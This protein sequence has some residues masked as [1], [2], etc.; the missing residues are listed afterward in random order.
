MIIINGKQVTAIHAGGKAVQMVYKG[1]RLVWQAVTSCFG[2]GW[3]R[4]DHV[5]KN[6][7]CWKND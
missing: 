2:A 7:D 5:W 4:N 6:D 3:W 1:A